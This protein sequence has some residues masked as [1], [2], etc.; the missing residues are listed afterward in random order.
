MYND[1]EELAKEVELFKSNMA[2]SSQLCSIL[3]DIFEHLKTTDDMFNEKHKNYLAEIK[4]S[5]INIESQSKIV[6]QEYLQI[7][8]KQKIDID[9]RNSVFITKL[10]K[11]LENNNAQQDIF[12]KKSNEILD[13][14]KDLETQE[15]LIEINKIKLKITLLF[16]VV[17]IGIV[18]TI[19]SVLLK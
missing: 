16:R 9:E 2:E 13:K 17:I 7:V 10:S 1:I 15:L 14:F 3:N 11:I 5:N 4:E 8:E 18:L 12:E 6:T 19:I